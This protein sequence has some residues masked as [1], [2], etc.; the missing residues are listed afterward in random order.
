MRQLKSCGVIV[1]RTEPQLSFLLMQHPDRYDL[2]KG[3]INPGEDEL[4][5]ALRELYEETGIE[6]SDL[7]L[8]PTF[9]FTTIYHTR[10]HRYGNETVK[11][12][13]VIFLGWLQ[14][15]VTIKL[16][17]HRNYTWMAWHP[18]HAFHKKTIDPVLEYLE[19]Y[20]NKNTV[21]I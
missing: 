3:H 2:P 19:Q 15:E 20:L 16:S 5:C 17:E 7:H 6:A 10:Y 11:K 8:D 1:M 14:K 13:L 12:T 4:S 21:S 18:P 9:R